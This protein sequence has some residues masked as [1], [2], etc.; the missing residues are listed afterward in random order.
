MTE[1]KNIIVTGSNKGLGFGIVE[2]L[3]KNSNNKIIM[4]CRNVD[5]ANPAKT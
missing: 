5:K 2:D 1:T 4:A 3:A